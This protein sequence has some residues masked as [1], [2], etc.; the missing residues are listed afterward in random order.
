[1]SS[2]KTASTLGFKISNHVPVYVLMEVGLTVLIFRKSSAEEV[3]YKPSKHPSFQHQKS[4]KDQCNEPFFPPFSLVSSSLCSFFVRD[5]SRMEWF[6]F[7]LCSCSFRYW[8]GPN[9]CVL[10]YKLPTVEAHLFIPHC[11]P[12]PTRFSVITAPNASFTPLAGIW[13]PYCPTRPAHP[14]PKA[15]LRVAFLLAF[16]L[17]RFLS[18]STAMKAIRA[19]LMRLIIGCALP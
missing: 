2:M 3:A 5:T 9:N 4:Q 7:L 19:F 11:F 18:A 14:A 13:Q 15:H 1:M 10:F 12:L 8:V 16:F 17:R 6:T